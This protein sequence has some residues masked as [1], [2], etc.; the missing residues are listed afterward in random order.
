[1]LTIIGGFHVCMKIDISTE[2]FLSVQTLAP[3]F[4]PKVPL[5][6]LDP[7][8]AAGPRIPLAG[9]PLFVAAV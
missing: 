4:S 7:V 1:M 2:L 8:L 3:Q 9:V 6:C 5:H